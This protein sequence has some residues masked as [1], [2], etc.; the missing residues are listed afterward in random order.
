[1]ILWPSAKKLPVPLPGAPAL[2]PYQASSSCDQ[3]HCWLSLHQTLLLQQSD[4][5]SVHQSFKPAGVQ[6]VHMLLHIGQQS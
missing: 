3:P 1:M 6:A 5:Y 4:A 2:E